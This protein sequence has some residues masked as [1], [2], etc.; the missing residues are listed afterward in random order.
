MTTPLGF[1]DKVNF[2][3]YPK[4]KQKWEKTSYVTQGTNIITAILSC[5]GT[6]LHGPRPQWHW[7]FGHHHWESTPKEHQ[8]SGYNQFITYVFCCEVI[9]HLKHLDIFQPCSYLVGR[10]NP[11][12]KISFGCW[13]LATCSWNRRPTVYVISTCLAFLRH[14]PS[15]SRQDWMGLNG[16]D[17]H[18]LMIYYFMI[19]TYYNIYI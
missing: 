5:H 2:D 9:P 7:E 3:P 13:K 1:R 11:S 12:E 17:I 16:M 8:D 14:S 19:I 15:Q 18:I 4:W 6:Y 10:F